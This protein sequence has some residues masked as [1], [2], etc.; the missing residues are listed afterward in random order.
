MLSFVTAI[1]G[2]CRKVLEQLALLS[3]AQQ[4]FVLCRDMAETNSETISEMTYG[5]MTSTDYNFQE[6]FEPL[7]ECGCSYKEASEE[8]YRGYYGRGDK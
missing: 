3:T 8:E 4:T 6:D 5:A 2:K 7:F 1:D